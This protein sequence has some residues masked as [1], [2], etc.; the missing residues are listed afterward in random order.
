M[1]I[2]VKIFYLNTTMKRYEYVRVK[3]SGIPDEITQQYQLA[4]LVHNGYV[5][6]KV[7][8]GMYG[9]PQAGI[10]AYNLLVKRLKK[11]G[12]APCTTTTG[13]WKHSDISFVLTIDDFGIKYVG[14]HNALHLI[15]AL[16][17]NYKTSID[18]TGTEY[19]G[20]DIDW[21]YR[22]KSVRISMPRYI[23]KLLHK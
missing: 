2:D 9:L 18:W 17:Q 22:N 16:Q 5:Y 13:L 20:L 4:N 6:L 14:R 8:K 21:N 7:R 11:H 10:L 15:S 1:T 3:L 12:Y 23:P 19:F